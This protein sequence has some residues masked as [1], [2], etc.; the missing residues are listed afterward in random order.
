MRN[1]KTSECKLLVTL[2]WLDIKKATTKPL[3]R[4]HLAAT[5]P[6]VD[7]PTSDAAIS[8]KIYKENER[9]IMF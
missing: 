5:I 2:D 7:S 1:F 9:S 4:S 6:T 8:I 3:T